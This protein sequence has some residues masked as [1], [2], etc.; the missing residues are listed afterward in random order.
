MYERKMS[1]ELYEEHANSLNMKQTV[2]SRSEHQS[3][4]FISTLKKIL[5]AMGADLKIVAHF[6]D[7]DVVINQFNDFL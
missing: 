7:G 6:P 2:I 4:I 3:D 5:C 1:E